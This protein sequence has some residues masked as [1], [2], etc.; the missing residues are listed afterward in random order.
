[1]STP[2]SVRSDRVASVPGG[3]IANVAAPTSSPSTDAAMRAVSR[4][5][6]GGSTRRTDTAT[7]TPSEAPPK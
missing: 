4:A 5:L 7:R 1:M 2:V 6:G 3:R